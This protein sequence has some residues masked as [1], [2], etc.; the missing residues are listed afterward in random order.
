MLAA[1]R[2]HCRLCGAAQLT[3]SFDLGDLASCGLFPS[4]ADGGDDPSAPLAIVRCQEC[5]LVQAGHDYEMSELFGH[6]YGYR[7][8][9]NESMKTHLEALVADLRTRVSLVAGDHVLDIG[10]NDSTL[11]NSYRKTGVTRVAIDPVLEQF[12]RY[13]DDDILTVADFFTASKYRNLV[14]AANAKAITSISMFYDLPD[15]VE[16]ARDIAAILDK[17]GLWVFEQSYMPTM[18]ERNS[19]DTICHEHLEY[20]CFKQVEIILREA[21][22]RAVDVAFN[23]TNGGSFRVFAAHLASSYEAND[24]HLD[25]VRQQEIALGFDTGAPLV[26]FSNRIERRKEEL[27][28]LLQDLKKKGKTVHGYGAS[29]KGNTLLQHYG[30]TTCLV[31]VIADRNEIKWGSRT[32]GTKI[33]IISEAESRAANPDFYL[34]LPW[35]FRDGFLER[36]KAFRKRGGKFIFPL[37]ELEIV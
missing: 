24:A 34:A 35:H 36:E 21:G 27:L 30:I 28:A 12:R 3:M 26:A 2:K 32:P 8:G 33:P 19:F 17:G 31:P 13:Y 9:L 6:T 5:G 11:L 23:E 16:F 15:P 25:Q 22:L 20:Y 10:S 29:T 7:S 4:I 14:G 37:P 18:V 1:E